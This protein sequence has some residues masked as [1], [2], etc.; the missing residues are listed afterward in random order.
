MFGFVVANMDRLNEEQR[1]LYRA[2]Y[3]GLCKALGSRHGF[4]CRMTLTYDMTFLILLLSSLADEAPTL[5][6]MRC[7]MHPLKQQQSFTSKFTDYGADMNLILA[8]AQRLDDW[9]D[10][11]KLLSLSQVKVLARSAQKA[12]AQH[13]RQVERIDKALADLSAMERAGETNPDLP[14]AAF[15]ALLGEVFVPQADMPQADV[16]RAF[17]SALGR[18]IYIM[19]AVIDL[20]SDLESERYNPLVTIPSSQHEDILNLLMAQCTELFEQLQVPRNKELLE[21]IL[22]S[23]VWTQYSAAKRKE[24]AKA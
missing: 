14:A 24:D 21:N 15:G 22:Y 7:L 19:D 20:K 2:A 9:Q 11:R 4:A 13:V 23:G 5:E 1:N 6:P 10:E 17:G 16:L 8:H 18:F 12:R 3:C